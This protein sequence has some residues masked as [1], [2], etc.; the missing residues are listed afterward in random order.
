MSWAVLS[1]EELTTEGTGQEVMVMPGHLFVQAVAGDS[2]HLHKHW[3][4]LNENQLPCGETWCQN[5][6]PFIHSKGWQKGAPEACPM[7]A[8]LERGHR[9]THSLFPNSR[10]CC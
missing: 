7:A 10:I 9:K 6:E 1:H 8:E 4:Y 3:K 2:Y 5:A